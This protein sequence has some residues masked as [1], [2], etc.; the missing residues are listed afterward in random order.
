MNEGDPEGGGG[1]SQLMRAKGGAIV[2]IDL[3]GQSPFAQSLDQ[4]VDE[5]L[6]VF[7]K[8]ELPMGNEAGV[9][10]QEGK[11]KTLTHLPV[12]DHRRPVHTVGLPE[13]IG[14]FGFIPSEIRLEALGLV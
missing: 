5:V 10:V 8:I 2:E 14:Q 11:E 12:N 6:E 7:L 9:V 4:A 1:V 13:I 3:S